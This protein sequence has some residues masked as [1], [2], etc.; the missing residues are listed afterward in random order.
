[1]KSKGTEWETIVTGPFQE[2]TYLVWAGG[3]NQALCIDPGDDLP[4]IMAALETNNLELACILGT[5][6]HVDHVGAVAGLRKETGAAF[7]FPA[8]DREQLAHLPQACLMLGLP[9]MEAPEVDLW[10]TP[11]QLVLNARVHAAIPEGVD[12]SVHH[13]PGHSAGSVCYEIDGLLFTGDT[14][15]LGSI[16][17]TDLPGGNERQIMESL[18]QLAALPGDLTVLP[19]HGPDTTIL[20]ER[21]ANPFLKNRP[22][23]AS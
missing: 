5:H 21:R 23:E 11:D 14:L 3:A 15:F 6:G 4:L 1:M 8:G 22:M 13:T 9:V 7:L 20:Q 18:D 12:I 17:R 19:G 2:N 16:G 10:I